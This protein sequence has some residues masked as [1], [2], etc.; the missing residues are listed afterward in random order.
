M[1]N[2]NVWFIAVKRFLKLPWLKMVI[3][4]YSNYSI[5]L[6]LIQ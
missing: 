6:Q 4:N 1:V 5:T 2:I 3:V